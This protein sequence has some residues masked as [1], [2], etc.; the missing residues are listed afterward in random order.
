MFCKNSK[1]HYAVDPSL[2][3]NIFYSFSQCHGPNLHSLDV[4]NL[5]QLLI[6]AD[7]AEILRFVEHLRRSAR[8]IE[9][10]VS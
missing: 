1:N 5:G 3:L 7:P 2:I 8:A 10:R 9:F 6:R 4:Q